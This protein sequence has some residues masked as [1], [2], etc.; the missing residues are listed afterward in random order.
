MIQ[1]PSPGK[2]LKKH[3]LYGLWRLQGK[4]H[5]CTLVRLNLLSNVK[6]V[7]T[8][9]V[10][11]DPRPLWKFARFIWKWSSLLHHTATYVE[12]ENTF[13]TASVLGSQRMRRMCLAKFEV[14]DRIF[15]TLLSYACM[16]VSRTLSGT[17]WLRRKSIAKDHSQLHNRPEEWLVCGRKKTK[18]GGRIYWSYTIVTSFICV[19]RVLFQPVNISLRKLHICRA[20]E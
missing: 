12:V 11:L 4:I 8:N 15:K 18:R 17:R 14:T 16:R 19:L 3:A 6:D 9:V 5:V 2:L 1:H 13:K 7:A 10:R 20:L